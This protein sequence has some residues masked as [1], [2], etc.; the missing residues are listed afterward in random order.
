MSGSRTIQFSGASPPVLKRSRFIRYDFDLNQEHFWLNVPSAYDGHEPWGL[1]V[2]IS[3]E[4]KTEELPEGWDQVLNDD[5]LLFICP[6]DAGNDQPNSRREGLGV[7]AAQEMM[8]F[9][10]ID[11]NRVYASGFSGGAR[12]AGRLAFHQSDIF[13]ATIQ[14]C[15]SDFYKPVPRAS[16]TDADRQAHPGDYGLVDAD[17][18][19]VENAKKQVKFVLITGTEDFRQHYIEDIYN[20]GFKAEDFSATLIS[21]SGMGHQPCPAHELRDALNFIENSP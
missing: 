14:C 20:G 16:V 21:V 8:K 11:P 19:E 15:G 3:P 18:M 12:Q 17:A 4:A 5:K 6:Q 10:S 1:V 7:V 13:R 9:Y 2:Y